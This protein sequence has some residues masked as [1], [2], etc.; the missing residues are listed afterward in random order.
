MWEYSVQHAGLKAYRVVRGVTQEEAE[1][2]AN[3]L[4][5]AWDEK[6]ARTQSALQ[7]KQEKLRVSFDI[8][9][10]KR[11]A[12]IQTEEL[13]GLLNALETILVTGL[14]QDPFRWLNLTNTTM[15]T[16]SRPSQ[17]ATS[18]KPI[19]PN[20]PNE[21]D[22]ETFALRLSFFESFLSSRRRKKEIQATAAFED[23]TM[24]W[25]EQCAAIDASHQRLLDAHNKAYQKAVRDYEARVNAWELAKDEH[26]AKQK[27]LNEQVK[28]LRDE[29][30]TGNASAVEYFFAEVMNH[31]TYPESF[32]KGNTLSF[33]QNSGVL[34]VDYEL[35]NQLA[36]PAIK[37]VKY[38]AA[39]EQF[40]E[41]PVSD[42]WL[43]KTYDEVLY[44]IALRTLHEL[45]I[46]DEAGVLKSVVFNGGFRASTRLL[47]LKRTDAFFQSRLNVK[48]SYRST[49]AKSS[50]NR[51][52]E[53]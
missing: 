15:F 7:A 42:A 22:P 45:Y 14:Q 35:P 47:E 36:F 26:R 27:A 9:T 24:K 53:N 51:A 18:I 34:I 17:P 38:I 4:I 21:P 2:K 25:R 1:L 46:A 28:A 30:K 32:P 20:Y 49:L 6:W 43:K 40:Q 23:A 11:T 37:E 12:R 8:D 52:S 48:S 19:K 16:E 5:A 44:Q 39:R 29:Y 31:S 41:V 33:N 3:L 10:N 13:E 50:Q